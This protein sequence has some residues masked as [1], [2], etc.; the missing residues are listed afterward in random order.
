M[1]DGSRQQDGERYRSIEQLDSS[2]QIRIPFEEKSW[3]VTAEYRAK[4]HFHEFHVQVEK[5]R[6]HI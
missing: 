4:A 5:K 2:A 6:R 1:F 3:T